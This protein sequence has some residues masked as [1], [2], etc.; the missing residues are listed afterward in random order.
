MSRDPRSERG[1]QLVGGLA[2]PRVAC[3]CRVKRVPHQQALGV[4]QDI[5][6]RPPGN[7]NTQGDALLPPQYLPL[8]SAGAIC[9]EVKRNH[10]L[11]RAKHARRSSRS[12][13]ITFE[14]PAASKKETRAEEGW[15]D[16]RG[17]RGGGPIEVGDDGGAV[18][19]AG[20]RVLVLCPLLLQNVPQEP[21][22]PAALAEYQEF[23]RARPAP[24][25]A[26]KC[27]AAVGMRSTMQ[28]GARSCL[29]HAR[30]GCCRS[31][32]E[33]FKIL[34]NASQGALIFSLGLFGNA[35]VRMALLSSSLAVTV[36]PTNN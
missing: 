18:L 25:L 29:D 32:V 24:Q 36:D 3:A 5:A 33:Q 30:Y 8:D 23:L 20:G 6:G 28:S 12:G 27:I 26:K 9:W 19:Q 10:W 7:C 4:T 11:P 21:A 1:T 34:H 35:V 14:V 2:S 17:R 16:V 13:N 22:D 31:G 15:E